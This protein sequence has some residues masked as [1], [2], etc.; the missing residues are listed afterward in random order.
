[1][2]R[3][4]NT[5]INDA[6]II[7]SNNQCRINCLKQLIT[8]NICF[9]NYNNLA[10]RI[11]EHLNYFDYDLKT[12]TTILEY[13]ESI[14]QNLSNNVDEYILKESNQTIEIHNLNRELS[15]Y[16]NN[17]Y[18]LQKENQSLKNI[19]LSNYEKINKNDFNN[20]NYH[21]VM[22]TPRNVKLNKSKTQRVKRVPDLQKTFSS[23]K[24]SENNNNEKSAVI[25]SKRINN[26]IKKKVKDENSR[27]KKEK[28]ESIIKEIYGDKD[29]LNELKLNFGNNIENQL[30]SGDIN[31]DYLLEI[32]EY[33]NK[34]R[35]H[36]SIISTSKRYLIQHKKKFSSIT[37]NS[38]R[39][40]FKK[41]N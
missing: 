40:K 2:I 24:L 11:V 22:T 28:I 10:D 26:S 17:I 35:N 27:D 3:H 36:N 5:S 19:D 4:Q 41:W 32:E 16:Q 6:L 7:I 1:M 15:K 8:S 9:L 33:L 29:K 23:P 30:L 39:N 18:K 34:R 21:T 20:N 12:L 13:F 38:R 37:N 25:K 14:Y 31:Y